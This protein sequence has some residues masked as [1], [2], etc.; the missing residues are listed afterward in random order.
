MAPLVALGVCFDGVVNL[1]I[2]VWIG[3]RRLLRLRVFDFFAWHPS[4]SL[5]LFC[6]LGSSE[7]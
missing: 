3:S 6:G 4:P 7:S 1:V 5:P 2:P